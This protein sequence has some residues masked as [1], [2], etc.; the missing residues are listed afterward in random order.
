MDTIASRIEA[1][2]AR[3]SL[4][5]AARALHGDATTGSGVSGNGLL[6]Q[7]GSASGVGNSAAIGSAGGAPGA[8]TQALHQ[9]LQSVDNTMAQADQIE[10]Q[11]QLGNPQVSLEQTVLA[12]QKASLSFQAAVQVRN[13]FVQAYTEIMSMNV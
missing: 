8:F 2:E 1:L 10:T 12:G 9:A 13:R 4:S 7:I 11:F 5:P 3:V 6:R